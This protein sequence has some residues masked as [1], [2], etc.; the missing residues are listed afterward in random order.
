M[1]AFMLYSKMMKDARCVEDKENTRLYVSDTVSNYIRKQVKEDVKKYVENLIL[2]KKL[3][4][5]SEE[6]FEEE[7]AIARLV[8]KSL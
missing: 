6:E 3:D 5:I 8:Y 2:D 1:K 7:I 4:I